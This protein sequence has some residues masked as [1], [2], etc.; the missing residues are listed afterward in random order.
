LFGRDAADRI[1]AP[2]SK[3]EQLLEL[4][5]APT[6]ES[7]SKLEQLLE[8]DNAPTTESDSKLEQ[9]LELDNVPTTES[10]VEVHA[11]DDAETLEYGHI[12][13]AEAILNLVRCAVFD[14]NL[15]SRVALVPTPARLK[16]LH[17][18]DQWHSSRAFTPLT[19]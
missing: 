11:L 5:N 7:D 17:A 3:L 18:C 9:L 13:E 14:R 1:G 4:G 19:G 12:D 16:R 10:D 2:D 6:T 8:L 15:H